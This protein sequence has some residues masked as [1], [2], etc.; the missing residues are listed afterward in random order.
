[1][2]IKSVF[3]FQLYLTSF[4][5]II[6]AM[7]IKSKMYLIPVS[8]IY[9]MVVV[10]HS[11]ASRFLCNNRDFTVADIGNGSMSF[12]GMICDASQKLLIFTRKIYSVGHWGLKML[13]SESWRWGVWGNTG[14]VT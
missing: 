4:A 6:D 11:F 8:A 10:R 5:D 9:G 13:W 14:S 2:S 7:Y 1:M 3:F 12:F